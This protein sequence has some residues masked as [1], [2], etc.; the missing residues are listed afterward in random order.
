MRRDRRPGGEQVCLSLRVAHVVGWQWRGGRIGRLGSQQLVRL[1]LQGLRPYPGGEVREHI[2][3]VP[4]LCGLPHARRRQASRHGGDA[5]AA[6][7]GLRVAH[8]HEPLPQRPGLRGADPGAGGGDDAR[9]ELLEV[10]GHAVARRAG[11]RRRPVP[12]GHDAVRDRGSILQLRRGEPLRAVYGAKCISQPGDDHRRWML[13]I[14]QPFCMNARFI[15][16]AVRARCLVGDPGVCVCVRVCARAR[17][18]VCNAKHL[19]LRRCEPRVSEG[20]HTLRAVAARES[21][22]PL[23][24]AS[25]VLDARVVTVVQARER[26]CSCRFAHAASGRS[27][28]GVGYVMYADWSF[29]RPC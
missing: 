6:G 9:R 17:S 24:R 12:A 27:E 7:E 25:C 11:H 23:L 14:R 10:A 13:A 3:A 15:G 1:H 28:A 29:G 2:V 5:L 19:W 21:R 8:R 18:R 22:P 16:I 20:G 26:S 4:G